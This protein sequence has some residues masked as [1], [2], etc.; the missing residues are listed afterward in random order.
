MADEMWRCK[1]HGENC[2]A[3]EYLENSQ[4]KAELRVT[5]LGDD[6]RQGFVCKTNEI[7]DCRKSL[8][9]DMKGLVT[10][11]EW[12]ASNR[13]VYLAVA[14]IILEAIKRYLT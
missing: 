6:M 11:A 7:K 3:I 5:K 1:D 9:E 12:K 8:S 2:K 10:V 13:S 14:L 4:E